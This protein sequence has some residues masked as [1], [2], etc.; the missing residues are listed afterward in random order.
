[1]HSPDATRGSPLPLPS[2][3]GRPLVIAHRGASGHRPEN[4]MAAYELA[5]EE[6]AD[7]IEV[8]LHVSRDGA[9]PIS[10]DATLERLGGQG[11]IADCELAVVQALDAGDGQRVPILSDVLDRFGDRIPF[12]LEL[13]QSTRGPYP[14]LP[15]AALAAVRERGLEADTLFSSFYRD[16]LAEL[17]GH[18]AEARVALLLSPQWP[19]K[20]IERARALRA[21]AINP[22]FT[23]AKPDLIDEAHAAGLAVYVYTVD[24]EAEM[25]RLIELGVDGLFTNQP[26]RMRILLER[27]ERR[28]G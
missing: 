5:V 13:K 23:M 2:E 17:R 14:G 27:R 3:A 24:D 21:E 22:H 20:P 4:T 19:E 10:H 9:I 26:H 8:D 18:S 11:E 15:A 6:R 16:V 1:M 7:M 28:T 12:N 25:E